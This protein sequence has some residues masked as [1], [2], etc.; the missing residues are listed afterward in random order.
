MIGQVDVVTEL[1]ELN[2]E[3]EQL[4]SQIV[5]SPDRIRRELDA[6]STTAEDEKA[7]GLEVE[8]Q[9]REM[10]GRLETVERAERD[11]SKLLGSVREVEDEATKHKDAVKAVKERK[12]RLDEHAAEDGEHTAHI[13]LLEKNMKRAEDKTAEFRQTAEHRRRVAAK[14]IGDATSELASWQSRLASEE[15]A[16]KEAEAAKGDVLQE[17]RG[18]VCVSKDGTG[19]EDVGQA[20]RAREAYSY[21]EH[22][23]D[24]VVF[25]VGVC[26]SLQRDAQRQVHADKLAAMKGAYTDLK[27]SVDEYHSRLLHQME[28]IS[29]ASL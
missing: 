7:A 13:A 20:C 17:V 26:F 3:I 23:A 2:R 5:S 21:L 18:D 11:I 28:Q 15:A 14:A 25:I 9:K 6:L 8:R 16:V 4:R 10:A 19:Q 24:I 29:G 1:E 22:A 27:E 12:S